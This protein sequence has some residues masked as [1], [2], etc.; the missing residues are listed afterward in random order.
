[1]IRKKKEKSKQ[2]LVNFGWVSCKIKYR[3]VDNR[4][5]FELVL[6]HPYYGEKRNLSKTPSIII[7]DRILSNLQK[8]PKFASTTIN[9]IMI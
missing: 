5:T 4:Y 6:V 1:M 2:K 9:I 8:L 3:E 7:L